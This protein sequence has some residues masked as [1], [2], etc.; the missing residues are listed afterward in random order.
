MLSQALK[1]VQK[2]LDH[3]I[4][5]NGG[6]VGEVLLANIATLDTNEPPSEG[7]IVSLV[8]IEEER[9]LKNVSSHALSPVTGRVEYTNPPIH[10]NLY[11]L[12]AANFPNYEKNLR[13]LSLVIRFFQGKSVFTA[14]N[15]VIIPSDNI[16][17]SPNFRLLFNIYTLTFEQLNHL[18]G[19]LGGKQFPHV[20]Y[21]AWLVEEKDNK[22]IGSGDVIVDV[23]GNLSAN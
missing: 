14:Q 18:W 7:L 23:E 17:L 5:Q 9:T 22:P 19:S 6:S 8:N 2:E 3:Y 15:S 4:A 16:E 10:L 21:R 1:L 12:F 20:L 11:L 13:M